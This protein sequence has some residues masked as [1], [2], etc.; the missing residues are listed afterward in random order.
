[1]RKTWAIIAV[2]ALAMAAVFCLSACEAENEDPYAGHW[3]CSAVDAGD[4]QVIQVADVAEA[5]VTGED[6]MW[7]DLQADGVAKV[8][9]FGGEASSDPKMTWNVADNGNIEVITDS[10]ESMLLQY[11]SEEQTLEMNVQGQK[12]FFSRQQQ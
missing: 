4:G 3:V 7:F 9:T 2:L 8:S 11:N 12:V 5:G 1:M 6:L 10:G